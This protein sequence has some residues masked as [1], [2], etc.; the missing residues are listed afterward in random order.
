MGAGSRSVFWGEIC[1]TQDRPL[2]SVQVSVTEHTHSAVL[3]PPALPCGWRGE[4]NREPALGVS[5]HTPRSPE[6]WFGE[7]RPLRAA[8][9]L[10]KWEETQSPR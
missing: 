3:P 7:Q 2:R 8:A 5:V 1:V 9:L 4:K 6:A 10:H